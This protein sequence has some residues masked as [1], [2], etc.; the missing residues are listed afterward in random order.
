MGAKLRGGG[1]GEEA[2]GGEAG[3]AGGWTVGRCGRCSHGQ[4]LLLHTPKERHHLAPRHLPFRRGRGKKEEEE[5]D[6]TY[7]TFACQVSSGSYI[8]RG[9]AFGVK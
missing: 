4:D 9:A 1:G 8:I 2:A 5:D 3:D 6:E 7:V